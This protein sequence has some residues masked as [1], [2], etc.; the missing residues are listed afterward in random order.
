MFEISKNEGERHGKMPSFGRNA[1]PSPPVKEVPEVKPQVNAEK[2]R[3]E[4]VVVNKLKVEE[5]VV[6]EEVVVPPVQ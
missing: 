6:K 5:Q 3:E 1:K 2:P 4:E